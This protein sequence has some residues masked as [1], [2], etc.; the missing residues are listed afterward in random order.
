M[1]R[2]RLADEG[3]SFDIL[4]WRNEPLSVAMSLS[5]AAVRPSDHEEWFS[6][7]L[8]DPDRR[9]VIASLETEKVG[10]VRFDRR[11]DQAVVSVA[12]NPA[13]RGKGLA[14]S[15]LT[16]AEDMIQTWRPLTLIAVILPENMAS[17]RT[18]EG[19]G[20]AFSRPS[21]GDPRSL[22]FTKRLG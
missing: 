13:T 12:L 16:G 21:G 2:F 8:R 22:E 5:G 15:V 20:Y 3:D 19:A 9:I 6:R 1:L 7:A 17:R 18:F 10:V 4:D 11:E 14:R